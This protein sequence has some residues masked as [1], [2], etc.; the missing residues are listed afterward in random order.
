[1]NPLAQEGTT[2][3]ISQLFSFQK[4]FFFFRFA[5]FIFEK[6]ARLR[7]LFPPEY[8]GLFLLKD[9]LPLFIPKN[10]NLRG[11]GVVKTTTSGG[12]GL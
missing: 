8:V 4:F 2:S 12:W 11:L 9:S 6:V 3:W 5:F 7:M 10:N 1:M